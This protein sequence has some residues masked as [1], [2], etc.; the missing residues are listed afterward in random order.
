MLMGIPRLE[1]RA[2]GDCDEGRSY[3][4]DKSGV[5]RDAEVLDEVDYPDAP[6]RVSDI[7]GRDGDVAE[8]EAGVG[9][10]LEVVDEFH[11]A[12][13]CPGGA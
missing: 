2:H 10:S 12:D 13:A 1:P 11:R 8:R 4:D 5:G 3:R 6:A 9:E 7:V